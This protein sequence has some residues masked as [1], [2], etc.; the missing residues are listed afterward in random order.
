MVKKIQI[1]ADA[2]FDLPI[3]LIEKYDIDF[4]PLRIVF[5]D[6]IRQQYIDLPNKEFYDRLVAG[7][8]PTTGVP[9]PKIIKDMIDKA[10]EK[11]EEVI[12]FTISSQLSGVYSTVSLVVKQFFDEKVTVIDSRCATLQYGLLVL[13]VAR[14]LEKGASKQE[15]IDY[16]QELIPKTH[17]ISAAA[18]LKYLRRSGRISRIQSLI[19]EILRIKPIFHINEEGLLEAPGRI[20]LG[21]SLFEAFKKLVEKIAGNQ[22]VETVFIGYSGNIEKAKELVEHFRK[23]PNAPEEILIG[24][25]GPAI[26]VHVGPDTIGIAWIGEYDE[27]WFDDL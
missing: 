14:K 4:I 5:E 17:L 10:L 9:P 23:Q 15:L 3:E 21:K 8:S 13:E 7:E 26:G 12:V 1:V 25:V 18:T 6:E 19:G 24:E 2:T 22:Q 16:A 27:Q 20:M 11:A